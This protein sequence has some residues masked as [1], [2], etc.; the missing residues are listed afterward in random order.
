MRIS[1]GTHWTA[2]G[3]G[4]PSCPLRSC[5]L[6]QAEACNIR[7]LWTGRAILFNLPRNP[8]SGGLLP[9]V[10]RNALAQRLALDGNC[11][12]CTPVLGKEEAVGLLHEHPFS[13]YSALSS[14]DAIFPGSWF[15]TAIASAQGSPCDEFLSR[16]FTS[17]ILPQVFGVEA[18]NWTRRQSKESGRRRT[19]QHLTPPGRKQ[20]ELLGQGNMSCF[21][22]A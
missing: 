12:G 13:P 16:E 4:T 21:L 18:E 8:C 15:S 1:C 11:F 7:L 10:S 9:D 5:I 17:R 22:T 2:S 3:H 20:M 6:S 14:P 19:R